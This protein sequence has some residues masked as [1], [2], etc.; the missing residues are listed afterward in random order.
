MK[1]RPQFNL[2]PR[3]AEQFKKIQDIAAARGIAVNEWILRQVECCEDMNLGLAEI[4]GLNRTADGKIEQLSD[5]GSCDNNQVAAEERVEGVDIGSRKSGR[6]KTVRAV[7]EAS[8]KCVGVQS[9]KNSE[10][11][12]VSEKEAVTLSQMCSYTEYDTDT[13]ETYKCGRTVHGPK[14]KHTRGEKIG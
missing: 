2:R 1:M 12:A 9:A 13:G 14:V 10:G 8:G 4:G 3:D 7:V 11:T 5:G 6:G